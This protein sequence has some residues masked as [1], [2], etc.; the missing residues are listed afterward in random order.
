MRPE[1]AAG[2]PA[3]E[4]L[5]P[6]RDPALAESFARGSA[7]EQRFTAV[8]RG[9]LARLL[10]AAPVAR[11]AASPQ[12]AGEAAHVGIPERGRD[13]FD[14]LAELERRALGAT[15]DTASPRFIGHMTSALPYFARPLSEL[16]TALNQNPVKVETS[17]ALTALEREALALLH[18]QIYGGDEGFYRRHGQDSESTLGVVT[19]GGTTA[20]LTALW[21]ARNA[22]WGPRPGFAG[23]A[24][25]GLAAAL[26]ASGHRRAVV[27][28]SE[29]AHYSLAKA[30][31]LLGLGEAGLHGVPV[32]AEGRVSIAAMREAIARCRQLGGR[33]IAIVGVAGSTESG[34]IDPLTELAELARE[35]D[36]HY[37]I[38]AAW[39]GPMLFSKRERGRLAGLEL[40]DSITIDGHKQLYLPLGIGALLLR[41][42]QRAAVIEKRASYIIR[43]GSPDLGRRSLEG[44]RA[45]AAVLLHAGLNLL[46]VRG[47]AELIDGGIARARSFAAAISARPAFELV[48]EPST[49]IVNYRYLPPA[50]RS[51]RS[52]SRGGA[53]GLDD[54]AGLSG[55]QQEHLNALNET[56]QRRQTAAGRS[57]V[58]R[59]TL[60]YTRHGRGV[61]VV[62]LRAVLANPLTRQTDLEAVLDEQQQIGDAIARAMV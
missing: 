49:N 35:A 3:H 60:R 2:E 32:D 52:A 27:L 17:G 18:R 19:S 57:F 33:V 15:V 59:T 6:R 62:V 39:A 22:A 45:A 50:L 54:T 34:T 4:D 55:E 28:A 53:A 1:P 25:E 31:D 24:R 43:P 5:S 26:A 10:A 61:P 44:S 40:A 36:A 56:L 46:G 8:V 9:Q 30:A 20:N 29:L 14:Y 13:P 23:V 11:G 7:L 12:L 41:E 37:H 38:D 48:V 42:P 58:S 21:I 51:F 16:I 47:Y